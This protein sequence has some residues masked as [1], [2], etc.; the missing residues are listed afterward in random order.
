MIS[1]IRNREELQEVPIMNNKALTDLII[2]ILKSIG[3]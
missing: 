2:H 1:N 3:S